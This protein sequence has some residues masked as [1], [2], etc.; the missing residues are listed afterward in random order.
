MSL[1]RSSHPEVFY[2]KRVLKEFSIF[3]GKHPRLSF[4]VNKNASCSPVPET[5]TQ[6]FSCKICETF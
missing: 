1:L 2:E 6:G 4:F 5:L 3:T